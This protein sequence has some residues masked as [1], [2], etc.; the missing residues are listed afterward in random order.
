MSKRIVDVGSCGYDH[1]MLQR[2]F[3]ST[4]GSSIEQANHWQDLSCLREKGPIDLVLVNRLLDADGSS[5]L[6]IVSRIVA[7]G[8]FAGTITMLVSNHESAQAEAIVRGA[9]RGFGKA[10]LQEPEV[11]I[12]LAAVLRSCVQPIFYEESSL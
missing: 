6:E 9:K 5:G 8:R 7:D 4:F 10:I 2:Y 12:L 11:E 1:G 3:S